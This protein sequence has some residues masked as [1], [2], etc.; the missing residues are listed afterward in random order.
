MSV[1]IADPRVHHGRNIPAMPVFV[2]QVEKHCLAVWS[3][4][5]RDKI[6]HLVSTIRAWNAQLWIEFHG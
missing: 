6:P 4:T 2:Q 5:L 1:M 3:Q